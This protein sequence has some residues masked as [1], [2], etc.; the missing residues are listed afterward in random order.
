VGKSSLLRREDDGP[1]FI[2]GS[3]A[4]LGLLGAQVNGP[5]HFGGEKIVDFP[6]RVLRVV[7]VER[8]PTRVGPPRC[9]PRRT[10]R[11]NQVESGSAHTGISNLLLRKR[12]TAATS[13]GSGGRKACGKRDRKRKDDE[14]CSERAQA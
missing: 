8:C 9:E 1:V 10:E 6:L 11:P 3:V 14:V 12:I 4:R 5:I 7:H 2:S 13:T